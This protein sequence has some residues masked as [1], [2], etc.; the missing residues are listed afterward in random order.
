MVLPS[1]QDRLRITDLVDS[2]EIALNQSG[3]ILNVPGAHRF[4]RMEDALEQSNAEF[5][6]IVVPPEYHKQA[7]L[8]TVK[9]NLHILSE[10]PIA[11]SLEDTHAIYDAVTGSSLKMAVTQNYRYEA[12]VMTLSETLKKGKLG[13]LDYLISRY[14]SD[15]RLPGSW[16]VGMVHKME[17]PLLLEGSIHHFD[18][19]RNLSGGDCESIMGLSWNPS[20]SSFDG[21][22]S[23]LFLMQMSNGV[24]AL[25]EGASSAAGITNRWHQELY[26]AE[27][28]K[29][30]VIVDN[31]R[32]VRLFRRSK[33]GQLIT[34]ELPLAEA[35]PTGH[36]RILDDFLNWLDGGDPP[37]T[38]L[39]DN[40]KSS[41]MVFAAIDASA[42]VN[43][44]V[45]VKDYLPASFEG[46]QL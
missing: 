7:V 2:D 34:E 36:H 37:E 24:K 12:P 38:G 13:Q 45:N 32:T 27:C 35:P 28:E 5:C 6:I 41:A 31:D 39:Q 16:E 1:F 20:W 26:R 25:Y 8:L 30:S 21:N 44:T 23:G 18:M 10:K 22:S 4:S 43:R 46:N 14:A 42:Q 9:K 29:G 11:F 15:Y 40:I 3:D 19:L 33:T 17:N